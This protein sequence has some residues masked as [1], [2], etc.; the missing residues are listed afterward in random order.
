ML[1]KRRE[2][3]G[4]EY[5]FMW[6]L[7][8]VALSEVLASCHP[9]G[10]QNFDVALRLLENLDILDKKIYYFVCVTNWQS[11]TVPVRL[12]CKSFNY[13]NMY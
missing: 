6:L 9:S 13:T 11:A 1:H 3:R 12:R 7:L 4:C 2:P 5:F 8:F 10:A